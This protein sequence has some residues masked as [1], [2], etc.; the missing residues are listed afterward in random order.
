MNP[1]VFGCIDIGNSDD[2]SKTFFNSLGISDALVV[3]NQYMWDE[4]C[5]KNK[6]SYDKEVLSLNLPGLKGSF[7]NELPEETQKLFED[8]RNS[9]LKKVGELYSLGKNVL[10]VSDEGSSIIA[11]SGEFVRNYCI[12]NN[13]NFKVMTGP[14][15]VINA[16]SASNILGS[17]SPFIFYGPIFSL[18][19]VD[20][21]LDNIDIA[22][23]N[24]LGVGFLTP[25]TA[26]VVV[27][28]MLKRFGNIEA[29]LCIDLTTDKEKI[30][31]K[32]LKEALIYLQEM[33]D[34]YY[35]KKEKVSIVFRKTRIQ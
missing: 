9:I 27:G 1:V 21:I 23:Y 30:V 24:F 4:F 33:G 13:I 10:V 16:I 35:M 19:Y 32:D 28:R 3:E 29:S 17:T 12:D 7:L 18:E 5:T 25:K 11:D 6:I 34:E 20:K 22:P 26:Q 8:N 15:A 14:S 31:G 2:I